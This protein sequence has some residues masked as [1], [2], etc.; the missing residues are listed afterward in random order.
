MKTMVASRHSIRMGN[1]DNGSVRTWRQ[2]GYEDDGSVT[3]QR[4]DG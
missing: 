2:D 3:T 4:Q 1:E